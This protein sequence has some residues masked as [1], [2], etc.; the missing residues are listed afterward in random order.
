MHLIHL[1]QCDAI[2]AYT[3]NTSPSMLDTTTFDIIVWVSLVP[4]ALTA[5]LRLCTRSA[6]TKAPFDALLSC[7]ALLA[8]CLSCILCT[9][10]TRFRNSGKLEPIF[11]QIHFGATFLQITCLWLVKASLLASYY[12]LT[13]PSTLLKRAWYLLFWLLVVSYTCAVVSYPFAGPSCDHGML[14]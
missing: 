4:V 1:R 12:N 7:L 9:I 11:G 10:L 2:T 6:F 3:S 5:F 13:T 8:L 14:R